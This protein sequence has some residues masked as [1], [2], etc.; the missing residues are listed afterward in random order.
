[1]VVGLIDFG[2]TFTKLCVVD[3]DKQ[4]IIGTSR[5]H[6][7]INTDILEGYN[8]AYN[9]LEK[10]IG[11]IKLD[12]TFAC[13]SAAGGLKIVAIGLVDELTSKA[14]TQ[15]ALG[16]GAKVLK[17]YSYELNRLEVK[18]IIDLKPD[19]I[20]LTGGTDGGNREVVIHNAKMISKIDLTIP[21]IYA[22]NKSAIDDVMD[23]LEEHNL[24]VCENVMAK[25]GTLSITNTKNTIRKIFLEN[26]IKAKGLSKVE[27]IINN[28][29]MPTPSA[30]LLGAELFS[31]GTR[32]QDGVGK[33]MILDIGGA[34]T[35]IHSIGDGMP[36]EV[37][38][39]LKGVEEPEVKRTVEGDL[40][41]RY[42]ANSIVEFIINN[43]ANISHDFS[44]DELYYYLKKIQE[45]PD[46]LATD[47]RFKAFDFLLAS[48][49]IKL[50]VRRHCGTIEK[51]HTPSGV[52]YSQ[53][54]KD[55]REFNTIIG[56][57]GPIINSD[58]SHSICSFSLYDET[59]K[60]SL[61]PVNGNFLIDKNYI[62]SAMGLLSTKYPE[63]A[64]TIMK[65]NIR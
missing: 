24:Y 1:M 12:E 30:V 54:G 48:V 35:D 31:K 32:N 55:L 53:S 19:I 17:T 20:L 60:N 43:S 47:E 49:C 15:A 36:K 6:T 41:V 34:T 62:L 57:G 52:M 61:R 44:K 11:K 10:K 51:F 58:K 25:I 42:N 21:I 46:I 16:A 3:T 14:A 39:I 26:I 50:A 23:H 65:E 56:T 9:D 18:E 2:S 27:K 63:V 59:E 33:L 37:N 4:C 45:S 7:T 38:V 28:I 29:M 40:G 22:G 5:S 8:N 13:S 64:M